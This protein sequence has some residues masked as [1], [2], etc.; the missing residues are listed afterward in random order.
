MPETKKD[1]LLREAIRTLEETIVRTKI[2]FESA[3][4]DV[5]EAE[6]RMK[7]RYDSSRT[8]SGYL[9]DGQAQRL[10]DFKNSLSHVRQVRLNGMCE[11]VKV[12]ALVFLC[13]EENDSCKQYFLLPG[14]G[15]DKL[16]YQTEE[17]TVLT[18]QSPLGKQL[19]GKEEGDEFQFRNNTYCISELS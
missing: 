1:Y 14:G 2:A 12:G 8:E 7:T 13:D 10:T 19:L 17:I 16:V 6:G 15:G 11:S 3:R 5:I 9:A 18:P 4:T